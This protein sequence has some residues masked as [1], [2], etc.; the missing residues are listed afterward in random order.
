MWLV[1]DRMTGLVKTK[2]PRAGRLISTCYTTR[3]EKARPPEQ[4]KSLKNRDAA[5]LRWPEE[6]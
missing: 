2:T 1:N 5:T 6:K 3:E 4:K